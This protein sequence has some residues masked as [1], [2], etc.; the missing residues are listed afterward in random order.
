[1]REIVESSIENAKDDMDTRFLIESKIKASRLLNEI[2]NVKDQIEVFA[3][4][5]IEN[6]NKTSNM[7][8]KELKTNNKDSI[9]DLVEILNEKTKNFAQKLI[10][11]NFENFVGKDLDVL[12]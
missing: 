10:D 3:Q 5:D 11:K 2:E 1:M 7:L 8:K 12:E 9:E 4:K 6:I